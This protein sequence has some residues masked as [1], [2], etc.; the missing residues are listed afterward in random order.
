MEKPFESIVVIGGGPVGCEYA[1]IM[2]A[3]GLEVT[4]TDMAEDLVSFM[5]HEISTLLAD[6]FRRGGMNLV[7]GQGSSTIERDEKGLRVVMGDGTEI[8]PNKVL[9]AAGRSGNSEGLELEGAGVKL[10]E[11]KRV[12]IDDRYQT[13]LEGVFAAGD[14]IGPP[15]LAS[16]SMEQ[17]R[18]AICHAFGIPF[19]QK[20]DP[21][22][23]LGVYSVPEVAAVGTTEEEAQ[24]KGIDYEV[25]RASFSD[26]TRARITGLMDGLIKLIFRKDDLR[27][28]GAHI[29]GDQATELIHLGQS[30]MHHDGQI[31]DFIETTYNVPARSEIYKYAAYDGLG[32]LQRFDCIKDVSPTRPAV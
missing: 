3:L 29:I 11:R 32:R 17:G 23:P 20:V 24:Q 8:R 2:A 28:L 4:L 15:A 22:P 10:D 16:V 27:L 21:V 9:F 1:S 30:V 13:N 14:L 26:N 5:D 31:D 18:V 19:K 7:L 25:G 12:L 6:S